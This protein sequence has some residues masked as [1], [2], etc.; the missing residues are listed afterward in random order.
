MK[1]KA[2]IDLVPMFN[3]LSDKEK[4][5][6]A[7]ISKSKY[8]E[9]GELLF[10]QGSKSGDLYI[11][12]KGH[13]KISRYTF[14]GKEQI[15]RTLKPGSFTGELSLFSEQTHHNFAMVLD[16]T[17]ICL[18]E[19]DA[20]K[21]LLLEMPHISIKLLEAVTDRLGQ[22]ETRIKDLGTKDVESRIA[23]HLLDLANGVKLVKIPYSKG[24]MAS[25]LGTSPET[26]SRNLKR[27]QTN[28]LIRMEGQRK[29]HLIN[30]E[31]LEALI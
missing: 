11:V 21:N 23:K 16:N 13:V 18:L 17:E 20:F 9:K 28:G 29:F 6:I 27:L 5:A 22:S 8:Y 1:H 25:L 3:T 12:H 31:G 30:K 7:V 10:D 15:I 4:E 26:L 14:D 24:E 19:G 2:C